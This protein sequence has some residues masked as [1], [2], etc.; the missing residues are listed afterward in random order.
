MNTI[1]IYEYLEKYNW[2]VTE[3]FDMV[4]EEVEK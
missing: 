3:N 4:I 2:K 1:K